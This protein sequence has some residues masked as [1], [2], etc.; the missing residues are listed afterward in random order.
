MVEG[1]KLFAEVFLQRRAV[2]DV[3]AMF[4]LQVAQFRDKL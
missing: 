3:R 2:A 1:L 4:V